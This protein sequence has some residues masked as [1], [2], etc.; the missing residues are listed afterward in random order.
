M[1]NIEKAAAKPTSKAA[2]VPRAKHCACTN[3]GDTH[4][5]PTGKKCLRVPI[6]HQEQ[7]PDQ[8]SPVD[9]NTEV[10]R[11]N[12]TST[13][14]NASVNATQGTVTNNNIIHTAG[15]STVMCT[16][17][18]EGANF[19]DQGAKANAHVNTVVKAS[20]LAV[21]NMLVHL[22]HAVSVINSKLG[23]MGG[24]VQELKAK[25]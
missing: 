21:T 24:D 7:F 23:I 17:V 2:S 13:P 4:L 3:C 22:A 15:G 18:A 19:A 10:D 12:K 25:S 1:I 6:L 8:L 20:H 14:R 5:P 11:V 16:E 9:A